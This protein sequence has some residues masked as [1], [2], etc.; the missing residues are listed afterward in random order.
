MNRKKGFFLVFVLAYLYE[1]IRAIDN[2]SDG[3]TR[4][5][6]ISI[7]QACKYCIQIG[8]LS[9]LCIIIYVLNN[10]KCTC[11]ISKRLFV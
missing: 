1:H 3:K 7:A 9:H 4:H 6:Y 10:V 5:I 8:Q 11:V 2:I